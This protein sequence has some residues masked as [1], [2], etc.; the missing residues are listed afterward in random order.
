MKIVIKNVSKTATVVL[1]LACKWQVISSYLQ[2]ILG[3]AAVGFEPT[4]PRE[5]VV[6]KTTVYANSTTPPF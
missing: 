2:K 3:V 1:H 6:L 5:A 4:I